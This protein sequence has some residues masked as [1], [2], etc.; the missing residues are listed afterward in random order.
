M[1]LPDEDKAAIVLNLRPDL[2]YQIK[3]DWELWARDGQLAPTWDWQT[4][5]LLS[6]RGFGKT[7]TG[8]EWIRRE[9]FL[10]KKKRL[11]LVA[12]TSADI[13]DVLIEGQS[14]LLN[15]SPPDFMPVYSPSK[16]RITW[17]NGAIATT[18][19]ADEPDLLRGP[20]HDGAWCDELAAWN[21]LQEAWDNLM[22]GLRLGVNP[23][24]VVTTTPRPLPMLKK[25]V[26]DPLTAVTRGSTYEN[27]A[28]LAPTFRKTVLEK[29]EGT[30]LGRQEIGG[31]ILDDTPG[32]LWNLAMIEATRIQTAPREFTRV[33]VAIDPAVTAG[34]DSDD[35]GI[36][37]AAKGK[38][39]RGYV[40]ADLTCH[41]SPLGW[42]KIALK[43]YEDYKA[44]RIVAEVNNGGD[45]VE[46]TL[47]TVNRN[48]PY[49]KVHASRGKTKRAEPISSLYEQGKI[50]HVGMFA[51]LE[52]QMCTY[53]PGDDKQKS[54]DRMDALV[55]G[56]T[57]LFERE[58]VRSAS[59]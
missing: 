33:V 59:W 23:Q 42:A 17:P 5:L 58:P 10:K 37:V 18:Y 45:L 44:D 30:R 12:R 1:T 14:G 49:S 22:L 56:L 54:P 51:K 47:R 6:G 7:R 27:L 43:A 57:E 55:W 41:E 26:A 31:E 36:V 8:A 25:L 53:V 32:A 48:V 34:E 50:S 52:D 38:D 20:E 46:T 13:R 24:V 40:L 15:I 2:A 19:S 16:R 21:Y 3:F 35:T 4:W 28:N 39:G 29:Y 9:V 11:A